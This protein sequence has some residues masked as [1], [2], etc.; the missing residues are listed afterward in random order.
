MQ[1]GDN[2]QFLPGAVVGCV[3]VCVPQGSAVFI[4][5][6]P[7]NICKLIL[8]SQIS[9]QKQHDT[10]SLLASS[11][12]QPPL[13]SEESRSHSAASGRMLHCQMMNLRWKSPEMPNTKPYP[14][15]AMGKICS[16]IQFLVESISKVNEGA[17][18]QKKNA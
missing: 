18:L 12:T 8:F 7:D 1:L 15:C 4:P 3:C 17:F 6:V 9:A 14:I 10:S 2:D 11:S 5:S 13:C 16:V